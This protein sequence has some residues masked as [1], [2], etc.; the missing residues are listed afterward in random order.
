MT[1]GD[2]R[3]QGLR[4]WDARQWLT[5][6]LNRVAAMQGGQV[7]SQMTSRSGRLG[8]LDAV[9]AVVDAVVARGAAGSAMAAKELE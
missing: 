4:V 6:G 9:R 8:G 3:P 1:A 2:G 5:R 7:M